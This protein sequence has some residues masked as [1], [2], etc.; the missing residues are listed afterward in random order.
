MTERK[1]NRW[2]ERD[3]S[4]PGWYFVTMCCRD[5]NEYF[6][7]INADKMVLNESGEKARGCWL[8]IS[9]FYKNIEIDEYVIMPNHV[10]G[11]LKINVGTGQCPVRTGI[12][13]RYG[14]LSKAIKSY[15]NAVTNE[16]R[17][18][19]KI[20]DFGWQRSFFDRIIRDKMALG[21]IREYIKSNPV[22]WERD[23]NNLAIVGA[24]LVPA[25]KGEGVDEK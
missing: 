9:K 22:M 2:G 4:K 7:R 18:G 23:R 1:L 10:H 16:I 19:L 11:I 17:R 14:L 13:D 8:M 6:G 20:Q 3:Y 24:G 5:R 21:K 12:N 25:Q 15:K